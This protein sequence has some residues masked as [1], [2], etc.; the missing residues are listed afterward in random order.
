MTIAALGEWNPDVARG[1]WQADLLARAEKMQTVGFHRYGGTA[2]G[3]QRRHVALNCSPCGGHCTMRCLGTPRG[4]CL[5]PLEG[6][7]PRCESCLVE[8]ERGE[9]LGLDSDIDAVRVIAAAVIDQAFRDLRMKLYQ[10]DAYHF[11]TS[12]LWRTEN[13]W[14]ELV[15]SA[16][17]KRTIIERAQSAT[18]RARPREL[19]ERE[20]VFRGGAPGATPYDPTTRRDVQ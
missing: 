12:E 20:H 13:L 18:Y 5:F 11:L 14:R 3:N 7:G 15:D 17:A 16:I 9:P 4:V 8:L 10:P 6:A 2:V 19:K 1:R